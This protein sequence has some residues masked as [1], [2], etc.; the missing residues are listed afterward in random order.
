MLPGLLSN[1]Q[2]SPLLFTVISNNY[3]S[4]SPR[5]PGGPELLKRPL[6]VSR[7]EGIQISAQSLSIQPLINHSG[8]P[9]GPRPA[10]VHMSAT[11]PVW[12]SLCATEREREM[13]EKR[14]VGCIIFNDS[15]MAEMT[16]HLLFLSSSTLTLTS[17]THTLTPLFMCYKKLL[18]RVFV[19]LRLREKEN[20][21]IFYS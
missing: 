17:H 21:I 20:I 3:P 14:A 6:S 19:C 15:P 4:I 10:W 2:S 16:V 9:A 7:Q 12:L 5:I 11:R 1:A 13:I 18:M 8:I